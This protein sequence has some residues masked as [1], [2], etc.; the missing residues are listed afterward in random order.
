MSGLRSRRKG[1]RIELEIVKRHLEIGVSAR[2]V[3]LSGACADFPGDVM[4]DLPG[5]EPLR[6]EV[7]ARRDGF[8]TL[9]K[10]IEGNDLVVIRRD[11]EDPIVCL[12]WQTWASIVGR[13]EQ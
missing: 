8:R 9:A 4:I 10:W 12:P 6:C 5:R 2:K 11:R 1:A 7:K 13:Q 3:P